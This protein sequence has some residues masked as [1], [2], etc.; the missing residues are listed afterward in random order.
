MMKAF[1]RNQD[2][3]VTIAFSLLTPFIIFYFLWV[4]SSWQAM[5]I[6]LQTKAVLDFATLGG[7]TTGVA[8]RTS[9]SDI[10]AA[11]YIPVVGGDYG[12]NVKEYGADVATQ[13]LEENAYNTLPKSVA[14]QIV[15]QAKGFWLSEDEINYQNGGLMHFKVTN[16]KYRSLV[17]LLVKNWNFT[18]ESTAKCQ[19]R[20]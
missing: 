15:Q 18:I 4:V 8:E 14:K 2:G 1:Y 10:Q 7:A 19:P 5:Y 9:V 17:P 12:D 3:N 20:R 13:L 11:C 16:I 6:Q